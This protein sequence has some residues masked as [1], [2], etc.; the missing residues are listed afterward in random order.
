MDEKQTQKAQVRAAHAKELVEKRYQAMGTSSLEISPSGSHATPKTKWALKERRVEPEN[1]KELRKLQMLIEGKIE[2]TLAEPHRKLIKKTDYQIPGKKKKMTLFMCNDLLFIAEPKKESWKFKELTYY[3][4]IE[5]KELPDGNINFYSSVS[6]RVIH[7]IQVSVA[8]QADIL[9]IFRKLK[10]ELQQLDDERIQKAR[11]KAEET[12]RFFTQKYKKASYGDGEDDGSFVS[13]IDDSSEFSDDISQD[14][15]SSISSARSHSSGKGKA[16]DLP[17]LT[18]GFSSV[19]VMPTTYDDKSEKKSSS[20]DS[21]KEKK[22]SESV[23]EIPV[24]KREE[25]SANSV[26]ISPS[27]EPDPKLRK[28][29]Q[30]RTR[31][32]AKSISKAPS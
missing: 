9:Q 21:E 32:N 2:I 16:K 30:I 1:M 18:S 24:M 11:D 27:S 17:T 10:S 29:A 8:E 14:D 3:K 15:S 7:E 12:K 26:V 23:A 5:A 6:N 25:S 28:W 20:T 4:K 13:I 19:R 22:R 31:S